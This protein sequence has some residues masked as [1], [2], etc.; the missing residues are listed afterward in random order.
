MHRSR[1]TQAQ[2]T[3]SVSS[4]LGSNSPPRGSEFWTAGQRQSSF[5]HMSDASPPSLD[6]HGSYNNSGASTPAA[7]MYNASFTSSYPNAALK[8]RKPF[9]QRTLADGEKT[10]KPWT[11]NT[12]RKKTDRKAYWIFVLTVMLGVAGSVV[13][14]YFAYASVPKDKYCL[15]LEDNF[16]SPT[17]NRDIWTHEI[18]TGGFGNGQFEWTTDSTNNSFIEDGKL[19]LVPTLTSD[20]VGE[21]AVLNGYTLNT[22]ADNTC[23]SLN[24]TDANCAVISNSTTGVILPPVQ[25]ARLMTNF[26]R[27]IKFGR[28]EVKARMPTGDWLW[29]AVWMM[30]KDSVYGAWPRSGEI[31]IFESRGNVPTS[32]DDDA[33]NRMHS[34]L[35]FGPNYLFD[36]YGLASKARVLWRNFFNQKTHTFGLEW[37]EDHIYTWEHSPVYRN[38]QLDFK[39]QDFWSLGRFPTQMAN[40]T[41]LDNPWKGVQGEHKNIAPFDQDFYLILNVAV[42]GTNGYFKDGQNDDKPWSNDADNA[43][44]QFWAAKDKWLPTWPTDPKERGMAIESVKMWQKC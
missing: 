33:S 5:G 25:S 30:P 7:G 1:S 29:P 21:A 40:G 13:L 28:V 43:R 31:D 6:H 3:Q 9:A 15:V 37:T 36:G 4:P 22:T 24:R 8:Y 18:Q 27:S 19:Y 34:T 16:D 20:S 41:L 2:L 44:A 14:I 35:H 42:G 38:F 39:D 26:S 17:I 12:K 10:Y 32:R 23:T 11:E